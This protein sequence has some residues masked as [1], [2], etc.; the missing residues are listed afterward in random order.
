MTGPDGEVYPGWWDITEVEPPHRL[1]FDD[2]FADADGNAEES[3]PI[4]SSTVDRGPPA[5]APGWSMTATYPT[6][7]DM[8][9]MLD[10]GMEEGITQALNQV[11]GLLAA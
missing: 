9:K 4:G 1:G 8:Q 5:A 2:G 11:D 3:A 7:E 10:M 6:A